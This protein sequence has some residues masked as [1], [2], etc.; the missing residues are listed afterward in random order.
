LV[1]KRGRPGTV[2]G[3]VSTPN[4]ASNTVP[5]PAT[6]SR[7]KAVMVL[8]VALAAAAV[9]PLLFIPS[10]LGGAKTSNGER[11]VLETYARALNENDRSGAALDATRR[12]NTDGYWHDRG[13]GRR[14]VALADK[15]GQCWVLELD[16][17]DQASR[18][19][20][21]VADDCTGP[22]GKPGTATRP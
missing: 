17:E 14:A 8:L 18:V 6:S 7:R 3:M 12:V 20:K 22:I 21:A 11:A 9:A 13:N 10:V 2:T 16:S 4:T 1:V 5:K 19:R 15:G